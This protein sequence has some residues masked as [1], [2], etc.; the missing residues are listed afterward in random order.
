M[1]P[2]PPDVAQPEQRPVDQP[3]DVCGDRFEEGVFEMRGDRLVAILCATC[4]TQRG[5]DDE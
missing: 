4:Y 5:H 2:T 1:P 3:C